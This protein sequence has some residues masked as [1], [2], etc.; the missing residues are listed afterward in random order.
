[1]VEVFRKLWRVLRKD[2]TCWLNIGD[3][4]ASA[5]ST[6]RRNIIGNTSPALAERVDRLSGCLKDKDLCMMPARVAL[7]LQ[8]DGW[9]VRSDVV[10]SKPNPMP[11]SV[12]DRP[13][14]SHEYLFLLTKAE[15]YYYDADAVRESAIH[16]GRLVRASGHDA[17]NLDG[18]T[19]TNDR[20]TAAGFAKHDTLVSGRNKRSVWEVATQ[21]YPEAHFATFPEALVEP[22]ILAGTSEHGVCPECGAPWERVVE[23]GKA[24]T[25]PNHRNPPKRLERGQAGNV[26]A[27]N[28]GF[29]ASRLSGQEQAR[30]K[31]EHPDQTLGWRPTCDHD[32]APISATVLDPFAGSGTTCVVAQ[33]LGRRAIGVDLNADYLALAEKRLAQVSLPLGI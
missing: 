15:R 25:E 20:R 3:S 21:P 17:K 5:W 31:A 33:K 26:G 23:K 24:Q 14:R 18:A 16:E 19:P 22:C 1:M 9:W 32:R 6:S 13:T 28:M 4:Y 8:A 2:G 12:T 27:G 29:R 11:E 10:W 7:A 30:W